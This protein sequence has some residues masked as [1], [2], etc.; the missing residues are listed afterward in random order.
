[1]WF[2]HPSPASDVSTTEEISELAFMEVA[3]LIG[4]FEIQLWQVV[5]T[6]SSEKLLYHLT[7]W[8]SR[9][10]RA[11]GSWGSSLE[12]SDSSHPSFSP[13]SAS[14]LPIHP[15]ISTAC[16]FSPTTTLS[17]V[18]IW[19]CLSLAE[20]PYFFPETSICCEEAKINK[21]KVHDYNS[22]EIFQGY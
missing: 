17:C 12:P 6:N 1:M 2:R 16:A 7:G 11:V 20:S 19:S 22:T 3:L 5:A 10:S 18:L 9:L 15:P 4:K 8:Q 14:S 21:W 13:V